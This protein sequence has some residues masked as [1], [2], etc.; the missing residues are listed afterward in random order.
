ME[1]PGIHHFSIVSQLEDPAS[2]LAR[3][4]LRQ[5]GLA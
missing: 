4:I 3:A 2:D 1:M 5:M